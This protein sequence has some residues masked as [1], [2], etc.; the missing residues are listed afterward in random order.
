[1]LLVAAAE[2]SG[3]PTLVWGAAQRLGVSDK[4][5]TPAAS[6]GLLEIGAWVRFRHPLVR[7]GVYRAAPLSERQRGHAALAEVTDPEADPDRRA[8]HR[9]QAASGPEEEVA[10][11]L[12]RSAGR[13]K[14]RGG[15]RQRRRS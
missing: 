5:L 9:A 15:W 14:A 10:E 8:W 13:A 11:E 1:L 6:A 3:N 7:S 2:P 12:E 4:A